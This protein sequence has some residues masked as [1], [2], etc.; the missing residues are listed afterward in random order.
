MPRSE[1][2][3]LINRPVE[4]V[5]AYI[6]DPDNAP[7]WNGPVLEY[8]QTSEGPVGVG[9]TGQAAGL[10]FGRR[11]EVVWEVIEFELNRKHVT[12]STS[13]PVGFVHTVDYESVDEGTKVSLTFEYE[14]GGFFKLASPI[15]ASVGQR[16]AETACLNLWA[17]LRS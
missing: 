10:F 15:L 6:S 12:K 17:I 9:T 8:K 1:A 14:V 2:T 3:V 16:L 11:I 5:F 13:G 7:R 4:E